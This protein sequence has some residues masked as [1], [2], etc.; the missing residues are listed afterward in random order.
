MLQFFK[1]FTMINACFPIIYVLDIYPWNCQ[2]PLEKCLHLGLA[3]NCQ[4][5]C[6]RCTRTKLP[7]LLSKWRHHSTYM[8]KWWTWCPNF[9]GWTFWK[10]TRRM[11]SSYPGKK[12]MR[13]GRQDSGA[14]RKFQK[15]QLDSW[16]NKK[17]ITPHLLIFD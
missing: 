6:R 7:K 12:W 10:L 11:D 3:S 14:S 8:S 2:A 4:I 5:L 13:F 17:W 9:L 16:G 15:G 1:Y